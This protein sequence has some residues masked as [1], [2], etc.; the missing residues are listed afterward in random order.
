M[1]F[2]LTTTFD[3]FS[4]AIST[5]SH[6]VLVVGIRIVIIHLFMIQSSVLFCVFDMFDEAIIMMSDLG[7]LYL[8]NTKARATSTS[9]CAVNLLD[10]IKTC[11]RLACN[12]KSA[13]TKMNGNLTQQ[14]L[15]KIFWGGSYCHPVCLKLISYNGLLLH[16]IIIIIS[17]S[18]IILAV[19]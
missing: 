7:K 19:T 11:T 9:F 5:H 15:L 17:P 16:L 3:V 2:R 8:C 12:R 13:N 18:Q 6:I 10:S 1:K 14:L 4:I